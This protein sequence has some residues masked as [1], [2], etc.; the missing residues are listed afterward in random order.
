MMDRSKSNRCADLP[1][2]SR[3]W[4]IDRLDVA[5]LFI[6]GAGQ[7]Q[8]RGG[9]SELPDGGAATQAKVQAEART[10][11]QDRQTGCYARRDPRCRRGR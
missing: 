11:I 10:P 5:L 3:S 1:I 8:I 6:D 4:S 2:V 7:D 9:D